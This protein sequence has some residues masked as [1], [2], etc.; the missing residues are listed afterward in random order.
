MT[1]RSGE[2]LATTP[3]Y[4]TYSYNGGQQVQSAIVDVEWIT[5]ELSLQEI[6]NVPLGEGLRLNRETNP[7]FSTYT[8]YAAF[9]VMVAF[10][11]RSR[12]YKAMFLF[13]TRPDGTEDIS[14]FD[15]IVD[16]VGYFARN[17]AYP[18]S[19][20]HDQR[21]RGMIAEWL[22]SN[23]VTSPGG[24]HEVACDLVKLKCG[25]A[26]GDLNVSGAGRI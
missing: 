16:G 6:G 10:Q 9:S 12:S 11:G 15:L 3:G 18:G 26:S 25:V 20:L 14:S 24:E 4:S 2:V 13:G 19:L 21:N 17:S 7:K 23:Q 22:L 5:R 8:R 1:K